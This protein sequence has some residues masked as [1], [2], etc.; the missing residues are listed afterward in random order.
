MKPVDKKDLLR[1][2]KRLRNF[3]AWGVKRNVDP[4]A[5]RQALIMVLAMDSAAATDRG[6]NVENLCKFDMVARLKAQEF[7]DSIPEELRG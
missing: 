1:A 4:W 3:R 5:I 7:I 2:L 6:V